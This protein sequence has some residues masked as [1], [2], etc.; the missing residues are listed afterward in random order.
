MAAR[1]S[2]LV[3]LLAGAVLISLCSIAATAWLAARSTTVAIQ[4]EQGRAL[5]DDSKIYDAL[6]GYASTHPQWAGVD[7]LIDRL[8]RE[9]GR[10]ITLTTRTRKLIAGG[11]AD[12][13]SASTVA[14]DPFNVDPDL[15]GSDRIDSRAV[16]PFKLGA[17]DQGYLRDLANRLLSCVRGRTGMGVIETGPSGRPRV[18]GANAA[19]IDSCDT[20][21]ALDQ[22][23]PSEVKPIDQLRS[24]AE[25]CLVKR[26]IH[27]QIKVQ[28]DLSWTVFQPGVS[29]PVPQE[30][31]PGD[32]F[33]SCFT[34]ARQTQLEPYVAPAALLFV[35]T[36]SRA[37]AN[38]DLSPAN[39]KRIA[40][41][42]AAVLLITLIIS[43]AGGFRLVQPL[44][45]LTRASRQM[46]GGDEN[47]RVKVRGSDE[48][49]QLSQAFNE[50]ADSRVRT[51]SLRRAMVSDIAHEL[52]TPLSNIRGWLE[53]VEDGV[54]QPDQA[55]IASLSEEAALLQHIIDDLRDLATA[56]AGNLR[57]HPERV[58]LGN[59]FDQ[60]LSTYRPQAEHA[61][62]TLTAAT[63]GDIEL[64]ADPVRLRQAIGNLVTN[65]LRHTP[66]GGTVRLEARLE[67]EADARTTNPPANQTA[68]NSTEA[69]MGKAT[70]SGAGRSTGS[71]VGSSN[72]PGAG[73]STGPG[74][75]SSTGPG[76]G[77]S[78]G[79][80]VGNSTGAG[81][82]NSTG[83]GAGSSNGAGVGWTSGAAAGVVVIE[84]IDTG[85]GIRADDLPKVFDRFWRAEQSRNRHTGG[86]GLGLAIVR[87]LIEA[88]GGT[89]SATST[90]DG[91]STFTLRLPTTAAA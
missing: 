66:A 72:G 22:P 12:L 26:N 49:A 15:G 24:L 30:G 51:E 89:A 35:N 84:V 44:R 60:V 19:T 58:Y 25:S 76:A 17:A 43:I 79:A 82:G 6:L 42:A 48:I 28:A 57:I 64:D 62:I 50:L 13:D 37:S 32:K 67:T 3:R 16:G 81:V 53:A 88:H 39:Q 91:G 38:F 75:G 69:G 33:D 83:A 46:T 74:A 68:H 65:A 31:I 78:T 61:Q 36:P 45:A 23:R 70:G 18:V 20:S 5:A 56:D 55:L 71:D 10:Q 90:P 59:L 2:V 34:A 47:V 87:S 77:S 85:A 52:R 29:G 4:Q 54:T 73:S 63:A 7:A 11:T 80:G 27:L 14:V 8:T 40:G 21:H 9:T 1:R 86:S 41:V